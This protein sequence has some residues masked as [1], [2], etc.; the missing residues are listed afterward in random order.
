[1]RDAQHAEFHERCRGQVAA[2]GT[3][4]PLPSRAGPARAVDL[5]C[6]PEERLEHPRGGTSLAAW[7]MV[8]DAPWEQRAAQP[9]PAGGETEKR[10]LLCEDALARRRVALA[11][12]TVPRQETD[13]ECYPGR[14]QFT[15]SPT[16]PPW[17]EAERQIQA[18][19][20]DIDKLC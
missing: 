15:Y 13:K 1:M 16:I 12:L 7:P 19:Q 17:T 20:E 4:A 14:R 2:G 18:A 3:S 11:A 5:G 9:R 10:A 6:A 8:G